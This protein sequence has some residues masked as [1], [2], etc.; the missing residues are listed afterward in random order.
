MPRSPHGAGVP[1][2]VISLPAGTRIL[3]AAGSRTYAEVS[4]PQ[5]PGTDLQ[6]PSRLFS[7]LAPAISRRI[8][9]A[10]RPKRFT[11][12]RRHPAPLLVAFCH[13]RIRELVDTLCDLLIGMVH[14]ATR[15]R[16]GPR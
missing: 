16:T 1:A 2:L 4:G 6:L 5:R 12:L 14:K 13:L 9:G 11:R 3:I 8:A 10:P 15:S 7:G